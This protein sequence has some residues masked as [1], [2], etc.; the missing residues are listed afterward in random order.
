MIFP[1]LNTPI[2]TLFPNLYFKINNSNFLKNNQ[3][4]SLQPEYWVSFKRNR[5][6]TFW[7]PLKRFFQLNTFRF[8]SVVIWTLNELER[9]F[10]KRNR[11][12]ILI[13]WTDNVLKNIWRGSN[14]RKILKDVEPIE[15]NIGSI[16]CLSNIAKCRCSGAR[17][18]VKEN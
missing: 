4:Y 14:W 9:D 8:L 15:K 13:K 2:Q 17:W 10:S 18:C 6:D 16:I 5:R 12:T 3:N 11:H 1:F 7:F